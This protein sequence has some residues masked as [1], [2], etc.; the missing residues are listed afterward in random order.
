M[1]IKKK[2]NNIKKNFIFFLNNDIH[3]IKNRI[4]IILLKMRLGKK[5][6][7]KNMINKGLVRK[8]IFCKVCEQECEIICSKFFI[9]K[10]NNI[11][12]KKLQLICNFNMEANTSLLHYKL[13]F[14]QN[15]IDYAVYKNNKN[16]NELIYLGD[17]IYKILT[18]NDFFSSIFK[19]INHNVNFLYYDN[20]PYIKLNY[21]LDIKGYDISNNFINYKHLN[22]LLKWYIQTKLSNY[23]CECTP[24]DIKLHLNCNYNKLFNYGILK[25][26]N[27]INL[28]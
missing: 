20:M 15:N 7:K 17:I 21:Y 9:K 22:S 8:K 25:F 2:Y 24:I 1:K 4:L 14:N 11:L 12:K 27:I 19:Q 5:L 28:L 16:N 13:S 18:S 26:I 6:A 3:Y 23:I 10:I